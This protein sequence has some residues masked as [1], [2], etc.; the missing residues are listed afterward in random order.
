MTAIFLLLA[1]G[2]FLLLDL[3]KV[4][5]GRGCLRLLFCLRLRFCVFLVAFDF[6]S[7]SLVVPGSC[8]FLLTLGLLFAWN[9]LLLF[10]LVR[11]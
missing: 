4:L 5:L 11:L 10:G 7:W 6:L 3:S 8:L 9:L 1:L 2:I